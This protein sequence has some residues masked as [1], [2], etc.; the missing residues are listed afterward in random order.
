MKIMIGPRCRAPDRRAGGQTGR[1]AGGQAERRERG[2]ECERERE[3]VTTTAEWSVEG[4]IMGESWR[5]TGT[6]DCHRQDRGRSRAGTGLARGNE[7]EVAQV[8]VVWSLWCGIGLPSAF[9]SQA[10][11]QTLMPTLVP[12]LRRLVLLLTCSAPRLWFHALLAAV[13]Q[14]RPRQ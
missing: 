3:G 4:S 9:A 5:G 1:R 12:G 7:A 8:G 10:S 13:G 6:Y 14:A 11:T 2:R